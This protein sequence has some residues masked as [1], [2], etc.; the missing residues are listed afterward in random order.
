MENMSFKKIIEIIGSE[1]KALE[2][3]ETINL[4]SIRYFS[5]QTGGNIN[6]NSKSKFIEHNFQNLPRN[7][8]DYQNIDDEYGF[9]GFQFDQKIQ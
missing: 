8:I 6:N 1:L 7:I 9:D 5:E 4:N 3:M 2:L